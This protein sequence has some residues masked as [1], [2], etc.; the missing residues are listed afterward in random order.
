MKL[1][2]HG[3][4]STQTCYK[5]HHP[6]VIRTESFLEYNQHQVRQSRN[7]SLKMNN[8]YFHIT[9][10]YSPYPKCPPPYSPRPPNPP[11]YRSGPRGTPPVVSPPR[12]GVRRP[13]GGSEPYP[14]SGVRP[15]E[16]RGRGCRR[17][18]IHAYSWHRWHHLQPCECR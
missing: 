10:H 6:L 3:C 1:T 12:R 9:S 4:L 11:W 5:L 14:R 7:F 16:R 8:L 15:R 18:A 13:V 17:G 2:I